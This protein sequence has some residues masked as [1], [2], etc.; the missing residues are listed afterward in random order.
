M[1]YKTFRQLEAAIKLAADL[2]A[3]DEDGWTYEVVDCENGLGYVKVY[4]EDA[5]YVGDV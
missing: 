1:S 3:E 5:E 2:N 4:D